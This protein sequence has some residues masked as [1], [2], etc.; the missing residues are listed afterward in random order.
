MRILLALSAL[1][2]YQSMIE[3]MLTTT[4]KIGGVFFK[5]AESDVINGQHYADA[6]YCFAKYDKQHQS[7]VPFAWF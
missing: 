1:V 5:N 6:E 3:I 4:A 2:D 7:S